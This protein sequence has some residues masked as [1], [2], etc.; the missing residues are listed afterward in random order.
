MTQRQSN[1]RRTAMVILVMSIVIALVGSLMIRWF[2]NT[3]DADLRRINCAVIN[4]QVAGLT[5][6]VEQSK[7]FRDHDMSPEV[8]TYFAKIVPLREDT[9]EQA[10]ADQK[11]L[12]CRV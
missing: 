4:R 11:R 5:L 7:L 6:T 12:K 3:R 9:L 2:L 8:R 1:I 10:I